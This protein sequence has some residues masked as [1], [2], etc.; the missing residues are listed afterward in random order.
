MNEQMF[1]DAYIEAALWSTNDESDPETGGVP[2][3]QNYTKDDINPATLAQMEDDC[4]R[5]MRRHH[6]ALSKYNHPQYT[7]EEL[8]G[9]DFWLS[10]N[11]HGAG[12]FDRTDCLPKKVCDRL[13]NAARQWKE[14]N[15]YVGD[16]G[17]I[18]Q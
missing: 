11:G 3:D 7:A 14:V 16:D 17:K 18:Y 12:F 4:R 13:Q 10:R 9:H 5:F 1:I 8:G 15:L 6:V 2:L